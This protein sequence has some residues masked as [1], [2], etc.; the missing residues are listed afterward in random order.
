MSGA[1]TPAAAATLGAAIPVAASAALELDAGINVSL[2][3]V[4]AKL[5]GL[6]ALSAQLVITPPSLAASLSIA[7]DLV[8]ELTAAIALGVPEAALDLSMVAA[9][10]ADLTATVGD[11][12]ASLSFA[13]DLSALLGV[14]G[15]Q[16]WTYAGTLSELPAAAQVALSGSS[17]GVGVLIFAS[18]APAQTAMHT[19]FGF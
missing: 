9:A 15:I 8:T 19:C 13:A 12:T 11:L 1:F 7:V 14:G 16:M 6:V 18:A 2:P 3:E 17:G 4:Q 10:I 5:D